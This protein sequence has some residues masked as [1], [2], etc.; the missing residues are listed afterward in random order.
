MFPKRGSTAAGILL[1]FVL[2]L[3]GAGKTRGQDGKQDGSDLWHESDWWFGAAGAANLNFYGGTTQQ[4][5]GSLVTPAPFHKGFGVGP[6]LAAAAVWRPDPRKNDWGAQLH[7]GYDDRRG[8]FDDPPCP[9][10]LKL[11]A[12]PAYLSIEPSLLWA[13]FSGEFQLFAGPRLGLLWS[14]SLLNGEEKSFRYT[15]G[16]DAE[17]KGDFSKMRSIV[18]SGQIGAGYDFTW[19]GK[20]PRNRY[21]LTPFVSYQPRFGE[22]PRATDRD[23]EWWA[24]STVRIGASLLFGRARTTPGSDARFSVRAPAT[25]VAVRRI[26]E[27]YPLRNY[28]YFDSNSA[29]FSTR[30]T[31]LNAEQARTFREEHLQ[32]SFP[33]APT[34]R[35]RRQ[36]AVYHHLLNILGDRL[37]RNPGTTIILSGLSGTEGPRLGKARAMEVKRYIM[38]AFG[39]EEARIL[40]LEREEPALPMGRSAAELEMLRAENQR[41]EIS[42]VSPEMLLQVGEGDRFM[43][44]PVQIDGEAQGSDSVVFFAAAVRPRRE[45]PLPPFVWWLEI[46]DDSGTMRRFGPFTRPRE[47]LPAPLLL[48]SRARTAFTAVMIG[49]EGEGPFLRKQDAFILSQRNGGVHETLRYGIL[50]DID[51]ARAVSS[52]DRFLATEVAQRI[53]DTSTVVIRG[54]TDV[55]AETAYNLKLSKG[56]AQGVERIL[57][58]VVFRN[59]R[60]G[61]RFRTSWSGEDSAQAPYGNVF[62][63]ERNYNRTV[64]I[65]IVP[66]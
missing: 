16:A 54:R 22:D 35:T 32:D 7:L 48:G 13:P 64:I 1:A 51:Q 65:D 57:Q 21:R 30:N 39:I 47:T 61:V 58:D 8:T 44:K 10:G 36:M 41:V 18:Y 14:P 66:D 28:V 19:S 59:S 31:R 27:V 50:F 53:P 49:R 26:H 56:R 29:D 3:M 25:V 43:L 62:P 46:T 45:N 12:R 4:L 33:A 9:C 17:V 55:V 40:I 23:I 63:E 24:V 37:R 42:S 11:S 5:N 6:Y 34:G 2:V 15:R 60:Q 38:R 52:Y 20:D